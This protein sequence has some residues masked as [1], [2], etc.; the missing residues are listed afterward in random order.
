MS[1]HI[2]RKT[3]LPERLYYYLAD[4]GCHL[5][6]TLG[7]CV[8]EPEE[9]VVFKQ[10]FIDL[11]MP[12]SAVRGEQLEIKAIIHNI[13]PQ[14]SRSFHLDIKAVLFF[15]FS[16]GACG[17]HGDRRFCSFATSAYDSVQT[18][19][20]RKPLKVVSEGVLIP[21]QRENVELN[22]VK[23]GEKPIILKAEIPADRV[24]DTP[25]NTFISIAGEEVSPNS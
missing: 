18:D 22:P 2:N 3:D 9:M 7:I 15:P 25:A 19:G 16:P 14:R 23:N 11:K 17:V 24:P 4:L 12:Y 10:L 1:S 6:P 20:V 5:S 8:A 21:L 13:P